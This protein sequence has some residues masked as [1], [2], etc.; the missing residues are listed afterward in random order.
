ML[1]RN[2]QKDLQGSRFATGSVT[3]KAYWIKATLLY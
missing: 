1:T 2:P 3:V